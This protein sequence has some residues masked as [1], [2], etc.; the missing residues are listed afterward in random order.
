MESARDFIKQF[1]RNSIKLLFGKRSTN[2]LRCFRMIWMNGCGNTMIHV[3]TAGNIAM[4]K[5][6]C[7]YSWIPCHLQ[8]RKCC[9]IV[10]T[11]QTKRKYDGSSD[12]VVTST[13][14]FVRNFSMENLKIVLLKVSVYIHSLVVFLLIAF[15]MVWN[16]NNSIFINDKLDI[17][18][19]LRNNW[20]ALL[21]I[22]LLLWGW[23]YQYIFDYLVKGAYSQ[24]NTIKSIE[25]RTFDS[26]MVYFTSNIVPLLSFD[27][28]SNRYFAIAMLIVI[29]NGLI[30]IKTDMYY[31]NPTLAIFGGYR[32]FKVTFDKNH[33]HIVIT[34]NELKIG[35]RVKI[36]EISAN[37]FLGRQV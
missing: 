34:K 15:I 30:F 10:T 25:N 5:R 20:K 22:L 27:L 6:R 23:L 24:I 29:I 26:I 36:K 21:I 19:L 13:N 7:R 31:L 16:F 12:D 2:L 9:S 35:S 3:R 14:P 4:G 37:I 33:E 11:F 1:S 28:Q 32:I 18:S 8:K 17:L